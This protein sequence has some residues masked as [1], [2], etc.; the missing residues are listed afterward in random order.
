MSS[1]SFSELHLE[2][3]LKLDTETIQLQLTIALLSVYLVTNMLIS[4]YNF[5]FAGSRAVIPSSRRMV[6]IPPRRLRARVQPASM[7]SST[8][9]LK[10]RG[11]QRLPREE[12]KDDKLTISARTREQMNKNFPCDRLGLISRNLC[13]IS[14]FKVNLNSYEIFLMGALFEA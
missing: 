2:N 13:R 5:S 7:M 1:H 14:R 10:L 6:A 8:Q 11:K 4:S 3:I 12:Y 9:R